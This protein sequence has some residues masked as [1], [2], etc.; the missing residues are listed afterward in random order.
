MERNKAAN[1]AGCFSGLKGKLT[2]AGQADGR[3]CKGAGFLGKKFFRFDSNRGGD[4]GFLIFNF[5]RV[6]VEQQKQSPW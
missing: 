1:S 6:K 3:G 2:Q 4:F 5:S